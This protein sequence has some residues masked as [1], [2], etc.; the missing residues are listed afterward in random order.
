MRA[1]AVVAHEFYCQLA[2]RIAVVANRDQRVVFLVVVA[3]QHALWGRYL[4]RDRLQ[5]TQDIGALIVY[6]D[7]DVEARRGRG[8]R[9]TL[10]PWMWPQTSNTGLLLK[11]ASR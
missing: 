1:A 9:M 6:R 5:R 7:D 10:A 11:S 2:E 3:D 4:A 8:H